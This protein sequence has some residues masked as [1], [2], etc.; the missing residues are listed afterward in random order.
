LVDRQINEFSIVLINCV[1]FKS[2][3]VWRFVGMD[4]RDYLKYLVN[5]FL[6]KKTHM[7]DD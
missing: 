4:L 2:A 3:D 1:Q 6:F 5:Q 7:Y